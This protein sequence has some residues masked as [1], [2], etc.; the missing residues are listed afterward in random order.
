ML[1]L[2][3]FR[4]LARCYNAKIV[5]SFNMHTCDQVEQ[6]CDKAFMRSHKYARMQ[7]LFPSIV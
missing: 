6:T 5:I 4:K 3:C 1:L 2:V 7:H